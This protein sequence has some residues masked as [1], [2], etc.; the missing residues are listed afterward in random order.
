MLLYIISNQ[1]SVSVLSRDKFDYIVVETTGMA[2]PG[3]VASVF[4]VDDELNS[5]AR[6]S[7]DVSVIAISS[8]QCH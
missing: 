6:S 3:P 8:C 2:N 7:V 1:V 5:Q 4:W